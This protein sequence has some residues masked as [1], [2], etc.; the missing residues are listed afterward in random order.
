MTT[1]STILDALLARAR[2]NGDDRALLQKLRGRWA[3]TSWSGYATAVAEVAEGL[4]ALGVKPGDTV[5]VLVDNRPAMVYLDLGSQAIGAVSV[6][7]LTA[8]LHDD[9]VDV[10]TRLA[11]SVV[12]VQDTTWLDVVLVS[13]PNVRHIVHV[14]TAGISS[15]QDPRLV[16]YASMRENGRSAGAS[17]DSLARRATD[18]AADSLVTMVASSGATGPMRAFGFTAGQVIDAASVV[19]ARFPLKP[20]EFVLAQQPLAASGERAISLYSSIITGAV[21][22]F[23]ESVE[24]AAAAAGEIEPHFVHSPTALLDAS[25]FGS[26]QRLDRNR[27]LKKLV[28]R[29]WRKA[30]FGGKQASGFWHGLVGRFIVRLLGARR[31]RTVLVSG[32]SV[33]VRTAHFMRALRLPLVDTYTVSAC[34][35][36]VMLASNAEDGFDETLD[37]VETDV[38]TAGRLRLRGRL[39]SKDALA[40]GWYE[41]NDR[42]A[43]RNGKTVVLGP[44][45]LD[46]SIESVREIELVVAA[47]P[48][49]GRAVV[50]TG[51]GGVGILIEVEP[52][53]LSDW[54]QA[55]KVPFTTVATILD[56]VTAQ[57]LFVDEVKSLMERLSTRPNVSELRLLRRQLAVDSGDLTATG[58]LRRSRVAGLADVVVVRLG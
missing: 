37:G 57:Q 40:N 27:G 6:P 26:L 17:L 14:D 35:A 23:P 34:F 25:S 16:D 9:V 32:S 2:S 41:T 48:Y 44:A 47:S 36:P 43:Q 5:A 21:V 28:A 4:V 51:A 29:G 1:H 49:I 22:A 54:A 12:V 20:G 30:S 24:T 38:T 7:V 46:A 31:M 3:H 19:A 53:A 39:V 15:Y 8:A 10:L 42:V 56:N 45:M 11:P 52:L 13:M 50:T 55:N 58:K 33:Q 18:L